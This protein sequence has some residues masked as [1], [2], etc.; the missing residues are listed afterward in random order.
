MKFIKRR[1]TLIIAISLVVIA[2][3]L[4][5]CKTEEK[6][7]GK[8]KVVTTIFPVYDWTEQIVGEKD[9]DVDV[10]MLLSNGTDLHSYQPTAKDIKKIANCDIFIYVGVPNIR[11]SARAISARTFS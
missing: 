3:L 5:S 8:L 10:S 6:N 7:N 1:S 2:A 9:K 4:T 11:P